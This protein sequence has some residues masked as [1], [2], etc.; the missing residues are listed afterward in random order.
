MKFCSLRCCLLL[1]G[2]TPIAFR[3][4]LRQREVSPQK[5]GPYTIAGVRL[6]PLTTDSNTIYL[7]LRNFN[8]S[9]KGKQRIFSRINN[10][11]KLLKC[12]HRTF[13]TTDF[14]GFGGILNWNSGP[15]PDVITTR[16]LTVTWI[17]VLSEF[18]LLTYINT[19]KIDC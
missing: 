11:G 13:R 9:L 3:L 12:D 5:W 14:M 8:L 1:G 4:G 10:N 19:I 7:H 15:K 17:Y 6:Q 2:K 18:K 16:L